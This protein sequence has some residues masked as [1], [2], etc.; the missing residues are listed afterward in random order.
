MWA[1]WSHLLHP[2]TEI[3]ATKFKF[4]CTE[5]EHKAFDDINRTVAHDTLLAYPDFNKRFDINMDAR[6]YQL[7]AV[8]IQNGKTI[9]F[10]SRKWTKTQTQYTVIEKELLSILHAFIR[11]KIENIHRP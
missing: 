1:R 4:K 3:T 11:S 9:A 8:I 7:G 5:V 6:D 10:Y 2:L